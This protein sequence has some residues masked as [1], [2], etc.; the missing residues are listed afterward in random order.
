MIEYENAV[1]FARGSVWK[2]LPFD[3]YSVEQNGSA[4]YVILGIINKN[5]QKILLVL[6]IPKIRRDPNCI[7]KICETRYSV[8]AL[9][10]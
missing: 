4:S 10:K 8:G 5:P 9:L 6:P 2:R 1:I 7:S 3:W